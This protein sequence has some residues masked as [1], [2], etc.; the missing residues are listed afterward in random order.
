M[1]RCIPLG[2]SQALAP[3]FKALFETRQAPRTG[4]ESLERIRRARVPKKVLCFI[5]ASKAR[6]RG[7]RLIRVSAGIAAP[8]VGPFRGASKSIAHP[9][10][11]AWVGRPL[12]ARAR[13]TALPEPTRHTRELPRV[14]ARVSLAASI[15]AKVSA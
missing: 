10:K 12:R 6:E 13:P 14:R 2:L 11:P 5:T 8:R 1:V 4:L 3:P 15:R 7:A 9:S